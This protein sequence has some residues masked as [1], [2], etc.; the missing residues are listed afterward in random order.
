MLIPDP[1]SHAVASYCR[2]SGPDRVVS[3]ADGR[4]YLEFGPTEP[5]T[6][7]GFRLS[8]RQ[9]VDGKFSDDART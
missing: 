9:I 5:I 2:T 1:D 6:V 3:A 4:L 7:D 8:Y